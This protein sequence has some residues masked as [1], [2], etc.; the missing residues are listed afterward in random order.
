MCFKLKCSARNCFNV[1]QPP[2]NGTFG[3]L[4]A[5]RLGCT[6]LALI[7]SIGE[8]GAV[9]QQSV[10]VSLGVS[11]GRL[12]AFQNAGLRVSPPSP[13]TVSYTEKGRGPHNTFAWDMTPIARGQ[14]ATWTQRGH[15][16][17]QR[18]AAALVRMTQFSR[19]TN[20]I[21]CQQ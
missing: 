1:C 14:V 2:Y 10:P 6:C 11:D 12:G 4:I 18:W 13:R 9:R 15:L 16:S 8:F 17:Y 5:A 3:R 21:D 20:Y 19:L 7:C